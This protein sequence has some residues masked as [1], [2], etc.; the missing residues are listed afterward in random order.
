MRPITALGLTLLAFG[1]TLT[2]RADD[3]PRSPRPPDAREKAE[4]ELRLLETLPPLPEREKTFLPASSGGLDR[5]E[6]LPPLPVREKMAL[7]FVREHYPELAELVAALKPIRTDEYER[8]ISELYLNSRNLA[9]LRL[10]DPPRYEA[11]L[12][13]WK[14]KLK[15]HVL[16][17]ELATGTR[18]D[19]REPLHAALVRL[20]DAQLKLQ[21]LEQ[22][23][24]K[25]Q[26]QKLTERLE[27]TE[28][29]R[30]ALIEAQLREL[31]RN[32][33]DVGRVDANRGAALD[34]TELRGPVRSDPA[35][36]SAPIGAVAST[37]VADDRLTFPSVSED[38]CPL[39]TISVKT[40]D[41]NEA[42]AVLRK[43]PGKGPFPVLIYLH[44]GLNSMPLQVLQRTLRSPNMSRF[45]AAGYMTVAATRRP[46][47]PD[48]QM[49]LT[50]CLAIIE[51]IGKMPE[52][53][54][55]SVVLWGDSSGGCLALEVAGETPL[56]ALVLHEPDMTLFSGMI[57]R[58]A[59]FPDIVRN[60]E[61]YWTKEVEERTGK[62]IQNIHCPILIAHG[63]QHPTPKLNN[64][65]L[66]P[67]LQEAQKQVV[68]ILYENEPHG[69]SH[70]TGTPQA[71]KKF[72]EDSQSFLQKYLTTR[73]T[74]LD[75]SLI[76]ASSIE[77]SRPK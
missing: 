52:T 35:Q 6:N 71:E 48:P 40:R 16:A 45:L 12:E 60:P 51:T 29:N 28:K 65:F 38:P 68:V 56:C 34:R 23:A 49:Q 53:D 77:R 54:R 5:R 74:A 15:L 70:G 9:H 17:A 62:K 37:V 8:A 10:Q 18:A 26:L 58:N 21:R 69:F 55:Q 31:L 47:N 7:A 1:G 61:Q 11:S 44:G 57:T 72:F 30:D 27:R 4:R 19:P 36:D 22:A 3:E 59:R 39:Q 46:R 76:K 33:Q 13:A 63:D 42:L 73:P 64:Q 32:V 66:I 41:G 75:G 24:V 50:D 20:F 25:A 14:A 67:K 2:V 43:P